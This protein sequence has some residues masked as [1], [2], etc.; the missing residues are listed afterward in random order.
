MWATIK[1][2]Y[3]TMFFNLEMFH[4]FIFEVLHIVIA[5]ENKN[6]NMLHMKKMPKCEHDDPKKLVDE[7]S[8]T[9]EFSLQ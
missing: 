1:I 4:G 7:C 2:S 6:R 9:L 3:F 8:S 5:D